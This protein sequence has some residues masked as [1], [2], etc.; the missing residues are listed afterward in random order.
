LQ[1]PSAPLLAYEIVGF[2]NADK[3]TKNLE[4]LSRLLIKF[5]NQRS[6]SS[7][8]DEIMVA[9]G[10]YAGSIFT[11]CRIW[12]MVGTEVIL[13]EAGAL[14]TDLNGKSL[15]YSN[16]FDKTTELYTLCAAPPLIHKQIQKIIHRVK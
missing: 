11:H 9:K 5:P 16:P 3:I 8:F 15:D 7:V 12:D 4:I 13:T 6:S 14:Y 1:Q 10:A 2:D